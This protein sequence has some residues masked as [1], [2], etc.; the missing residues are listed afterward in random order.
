MDE[1]YPDLPENPLLTRTDTRLVIDIRDLHTKVP[2]SGG[3]LRRGLEAALP[4]FE[5]NG[6][7]AYVAYCSNFLL[8]LHK[9]DDLEDPD[10]TEETL[11]Y[12]YEM[13]EWGNV[14]VEARF[15]AMEEALRDMPDGHYECRFLV[16]WDNRGAGETDEYW[17]RHTKR[18]GS[19][20]RPLWFAPGNEVEGAH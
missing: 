20:Y 18:A 2:V 12:Y 11:T 3:A 16:D 5:R 17:G 9:H 10:V 13:G 8:S 19:T 14:W 1:F 7:S 6:V 4:V 15:V